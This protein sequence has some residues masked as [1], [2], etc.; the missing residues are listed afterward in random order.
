LIDNRQD[1][2]R[3]T[4]RQGIVHEV[5]AP[6]L[7]GPAG[8]GRDTAMLARVFATTQPIAQLQPFQAI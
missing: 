3:S 5:D 8:G 1:P 4:I 2:K 7:M 6:A